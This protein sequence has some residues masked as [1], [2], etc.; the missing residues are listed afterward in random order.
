MLATRGEPVQRSRSIQ[1]QPRILCGICPET[2]E[3]NSLATARECRTS[4]NTCAESKDAYWRIHSGAS[5]MEG[6]RGSCSPAAMQSLAR[7]PWMHTT[8]RR[9]QSKARRTRTPRLPNHD[10]QVL[11]ILLDAHQ[12]TLLAPVTLPRIRSLQQGHHA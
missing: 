4:L 8:K 12:A 7:T 5:N 6:N 3:A 11:Q 1:G 10:H 2:S 9:F